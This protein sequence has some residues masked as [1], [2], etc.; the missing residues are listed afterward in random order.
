MK[1]AKFN[2]NHIIGNLEEELLRYSKAET[3]MSSKS[4]RFLRIVLAV[5]VVLILALFVAA[6]VSPT[7][8]VKGFFMAERAWISV[9]P[10]ERGRYAFEKLEPLLCKA[11]I[12][13]PVRVEV[14][15]HMSFLLNPADVVPVTILRTGV[16]QPEVWHALEPSLHEGSVFLDVGAHIGYFTM[17][18]APKVG[19]AGHVLAFEPNPETLKLLYDN[20]AANGD[21]NVTVE[22]I[23]CTDKEETLTF[24][25]APVQNSGMSSLSKRNAEVEGAAPPKSYIVQGRPIDAVVRQLNLARVDA[26]KIDVEGA[27]VVVLRGAVETLKRFHPRLVIEE[28]PEELASFQTSMED[29]SSLLHNAGYNHT[30]RLLSHGDDYEW[31]ADD[32]IASA[33]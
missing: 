22:P 6:R 28:I 11:G 9:W 15:P 5:A 10:F 12:L 33:P 21:N 13:T 31:T 29:L 4:W 26:I 30:R 23:A 32:R 14:E 7:A 19:A 3:I 16:W 24:Y 8:T 20:V 18:A 27:E 25:A 2:R 17:K 1:R